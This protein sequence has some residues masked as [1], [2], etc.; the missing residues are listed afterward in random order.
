MKTST[1]TAIFERNIFRGNRRTEGFQIPLRIHLSMFGSSVEKNIL[2]SKITGWRPFYKVYVSSISMSNLSRDD[3]CHFAVCRAIFYF[4]IPTSYVSEVWSRI[5]CRL[6]H[7]CGHVSVSKKEAMSK[8][9]IL[10]FL[11]IDIVPSLN[12]TDVCNF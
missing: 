11:D 5:F 3:S 8:S 7:K 4:C 2:V 6:V 10:A 12:L 9:D 1:A